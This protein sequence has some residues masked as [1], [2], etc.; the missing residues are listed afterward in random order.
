MNRIRNYIKVY[1]IFFILAFTLGILTFSIGKSAITSKERNILRNDENKNKSITFID[2]EN[3]YLD[4]VLNLIKDN[5]VTVSLV[6]QVNENTVYNIKTIVKFD[7]LDMTDDMV[8]GEFLSKEEF[9][10]DKDEGVFTSTLTK[11]DTYTIENINEYDNKDITIKRKGTSF[12]IY[13]EIIVPQRKFFE[14]V[15]SK[16]LSLAEYGFIVHGED[17]EVKSTINK[18]EKFVKSKNKN[19]FITT[20]PYTM[21]NNNE[22]GEYLY[23]LSILIIVVIIVNSISI[24]Y[25]WVSKKKKELI[26]RKVCGATDYD[27]FKMFFGELTI[28]ALISACLAL[29]IQYILVKVTNGMI[30]TMD[31]RINLNNFTNSALV[32]IVTAYISALP[33]MLSIWKL[34][35]VDMLKEE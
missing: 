33:S 25:L 17:E 19:N 18:I 22:E 9:E 11:D 20:A 15:N 12:E 31:I 2:T 34:E 28:L 26:L 21:V 3:I 8:T 16:N 30:G 35:L 4:D 32:A 14:I 10:G 24:S 7:G 23:S 13:N 27:L 1:T 5:K 29:I 6:R